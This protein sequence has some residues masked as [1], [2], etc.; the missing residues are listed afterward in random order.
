MHILISSRLLWWVSGDRKEA[1][2]VTVYKA[3]YHCRMCGAHFAH[4][5]VD[6]DTAL[7]EA[8]EMVFDESTKEFGSGKLWRHQTHICC[9]GSIGFA[10]FLGFRKEVL[11][12]AED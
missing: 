1:K 7:M 9:D 4:T 3:I 8:T 2:L 6:H 5:T 10:D 11:S 12:E